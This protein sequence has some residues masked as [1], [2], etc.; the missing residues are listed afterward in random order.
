M[1]ICT[2]IYVLSEVTLFGGVIPLRVSNKT[3]SARHE[4]SP[5]ELSMKNPRGSQIIQAVAIAFGCL[6]ELESQILFLKTPG[7]HFRHRRKRPGSLLP[8]N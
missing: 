7:T 3:P 1:H 5:F 8:E 2:H 6:P 4:K